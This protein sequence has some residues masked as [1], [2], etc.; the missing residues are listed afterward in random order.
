M[1]S[2]NSEENDTSNLKVEFEAV[3]FSETLVYVLLTDLL[4]H[5]LT[6]WSRVLLEKLTCSQL[7]KRFPAFYGT[8]KF[9]T[10]RAKTRP[11]NPEVKM[12]NSPT[13][14]T[15]LFLR[16]LYHSITLNIPTW[17]YPQ[18]FTIREPNQNNKA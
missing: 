17:F 14:C 7:V 8:R 13:K 3:C 15:I 16:Y 6:P 18:G 12:L 11:R 10:Y 4:T 1:K 2:Q 5:L 9:I